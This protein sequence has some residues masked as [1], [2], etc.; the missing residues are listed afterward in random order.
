M[1]PDLVE[2]LAAVKRVVT[3]VIRPQVQDD[4]ALKQLQHIELALADLAASAPT[5][6]AWRLESLDTLTAILADLQSSSAPPGGEGALG[7]ILPDLREAL[8]FAPLSDY[9]SLGELETRIAAMRSVLSDA[10]PILNRREA[11]IAGGTEIKARIRAY[12]RKS[13]QRG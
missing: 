10:I 1:K 7:P 5:W 4:Y 13:A 9:P 6:F 8:A 2:T 12:L 11:D 3:E